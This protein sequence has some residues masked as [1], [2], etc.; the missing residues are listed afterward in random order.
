MKECYEILEWDSDYFGFK[1]AKINKGILSKELEDCFGQLKENNVKLAYYF[2]NLPLTSSV[3]ENKFYEVSL[4][5]KRIP[6][7]KTL[8]KSTVIHEK[9]SLY[10]KSYPEDELIELAQL[11][12]SYSRFGVD[13]HIPKDQF[14]KLFEIWIINSV[15]KEMA[16]DVLV[17]RE[18]DKII[19]FA[20]IKMEDG[21]AHTPLFAVARPFEGKGVSFALMRAIETILLE[22]GCTKVLGGTQEINIKAL[23]VYERY[24]LVV[25][26]PEYVYHFWRRN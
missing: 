16:S 22:R 24:G 7:I 6:L 13:V 18:K 3:I 23:K 4:V 26:K 1:V 19:G 21:I 2:S 12:G 10:N 11:A 14:N 17:Y 9:I 5:H 8:S 20:T 15:K 25:Q